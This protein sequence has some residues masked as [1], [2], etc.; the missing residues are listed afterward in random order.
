MI[1]IEEGTLTRETTLHGQKIAFLTKDIVEIDKVFSEHG[2]KPLQVKIEPQRVRRSLDANAYCWVLCDRIA[3]VLRS[4]KEEVYRR[5]I[6]E[7][8]VFQ[9]VAVQQGS[10]VKTLVQTWTSRGIGWIA[11]V[12][13]S[14]LIDRSGKRMMRV[15]LYSGS[16][17]YDTKEMSRL[18]DWLVDEAK[19][20]GIETLPEDELKRMLTTA[21]RSQ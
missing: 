12:F 7:V 4:T 2:K 6:R 17:I 19:G 21:E 9:D 8:G 11:E 13:D 18:I 14:S 5:A 1:R 3:D 20:L 15:R 16:H 10:A